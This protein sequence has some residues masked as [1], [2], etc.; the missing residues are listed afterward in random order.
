VD[1]TI[2]AEHVREY[3]GGLSRPIQILEAGCGRRWGLDMS[4]IDF[5]LTGVDINADSMRL[6][7]DTLGDLHEAIVGDLRTVDLKTEAYD[8]VYCSFVLEHVEGAE[9]VLDRLTKA[10]RPGGLL[11]L[12][13]PDRDAV[14]GFLARHTPHRS[15]VWY[16]RHIRKSRLA[17]TPGHGPFPV[18]YDDVVSARG[19]TDYCARNGLTVAYAGTD[20][21]HLRFFGRLEPV[22]DLGLHAFA[23]LSFGHLTADHANLSYVLKRD[24][25]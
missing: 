6:R 5:H 18:V 2:F 9:L 14:Y 13:I 16:K 23:A 20:N 3:A 21:A 4:G 10:L 19:I 7:M 8:V 25:A 11:L 17:G 15:H 1:E 12:R 24:P 22:V